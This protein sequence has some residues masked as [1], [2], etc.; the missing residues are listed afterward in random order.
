MSANEKKSMISWLFL[1]PSIVGVLL[2]FVAPFMVVIYYSMI[3]NPIQKRF[4]GFANYIN[5]WS[6][7]AFKLAGMNTLK[8]S[9]M[10][11]PLAVLLSLFLAAVMESR[12]PFKS[13]FRSFFL[14]PLMVPTASIVLIW[15]VM[16]HYNG[17]VNNFTALFGADKI[18]WLKSD[19]A[20]IVIV[21][22]FLWKNLGYNMILFMSALA[23]I[24]KELLEVA[25]LEN[26]S[27]MQVF[28]LIK[29]RYLSSTILFVTIMSL[30]NSF[31]VFREVYLM[32]GDYP[33]TSLYLLQHF[34]NNTFA[35]LDYQKLSAAAIIMFIVVTALV[36]IMYAVEN[37]YG[38]DV[39]G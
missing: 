39:E 14:S 33:V 12:I 20:Y 5:V 1:L 24:P 13:Y 37:F 3:N 22:L 21:A 8:F 30:I 23:S 35:S 10:A 7:D 31:K 9:F 15:Q 27:K 2:F 11:V 28:W 38:K 18:D 26:A 29:V 4:V 17:L 32:T 6:N 16:F 34:M 19:K 25:A 36:Y